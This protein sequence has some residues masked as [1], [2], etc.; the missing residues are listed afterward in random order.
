MCVFVVLCLSDK[1]RGEG[2]DREGDG[3]RGIAVRHLRKRKGVGEMAQW[4]ENGACQ[5][6]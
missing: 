4:I 3:N 1:T 2:S 6:A 5:Q